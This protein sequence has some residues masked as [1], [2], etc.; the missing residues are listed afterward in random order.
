MNPWRDGWEDT[1]KRVSVKSSTLARSDICSLVVCF[2]LS[3]CLSSY[4]YVGQD[5]PEAATFRGIPL[6]SPSLQEHRPLLKDLG[7]AMYVSELRRSE[8]LTG[9]GRRGVTLR[10]LGMFP[11]LVRLLRI[12][13]LDKRMQ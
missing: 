8:D 11:E 7:I 9:D 12:K 2:V 3:I 10:Q 4:P 1:L 13:G 6:Q 5:L